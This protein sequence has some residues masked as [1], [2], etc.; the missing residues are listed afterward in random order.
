MRKTLFGIGPALVALILATPAAWAQSRNFDDVAI[1]PH[2]VGGTVYMLTGAGGNM[3]ASVGPDGVFL[4]DDQYAPLTDKIIAA[5]ATLSDREV[6]FLINTHI[7]PD[8]VG[9]NENLGRMGVAIVG[10]D[11]IRARLADGFRGNPPPPAVAL[12]VITFAD[13]VTFHLNGEDARAIK[14]ANAHTDGDTIVHFTGAD[15]I[16]TG[17]MFRTTSFPVIDTT[18]GGTYRGTLEALDQ[19][20]ALA[21]PATK[22]IPGH[23]VITDRAMVETFRAM[24]AAIG[25]RV[26][27]M[28]DDGQM[29]EA[30]VAAKVTAAY[31]ER[32]DF[33]PGFFVT[34][35]D[36]VAT[37]YNELKAIAN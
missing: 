17:D 4:I 29:L 21:G 5:L 25:D 24:V 6:R 3:G 2:H 35:D 12:P 30:V 19:V 10:H 13:S 7:H 1:V 27:S 28:I 15:V 23:G 36:L 37:I 20:I 33:R 14:V 8:H 9:G 26:Q 18:H 11:T 16:H 22:I 34:K 32:W 31:D